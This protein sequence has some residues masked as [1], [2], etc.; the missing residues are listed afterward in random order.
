[1]IRFIYFMVLTGLFTLF[2][3]HEEEGP[4][5]RFLLLTT[6]TWES[7]DLLVNGEDASGEG[8]VLENFQGEA[9]FY[10][11]RSGYFGQYTG[12]WGFAQNETELEIFSEAI[13]FVLST[14]IEELTTTS[15]KVT[16]SYP[17]VLNPEEPLQIRMTF[18]AK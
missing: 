15:L 12:S 6:P 11:D 17:N 9:K 16:T 10:E 3:C 1:M 5:E 8:Q 7:N 18:I 2:A 14:S 4:S 13:G